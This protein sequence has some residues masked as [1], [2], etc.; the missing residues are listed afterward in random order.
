MDYN[1]L[2]QRA[3]AAYLDMFPPFV[4][5][6][7]AD[8]DMQEEFYSLMKNL[9]QL[10]FDEP[11]LL[12][13]KLNEDDSFPSRYKKPYGKPEL[14][15]NTLKL[16]KAM[17]ML[18]QNM[19]LLGQ[20]EEVN[21]SKKHSDILSRLGVKDTGTLPEGWKW[22][23][24]RE[25]ANLSAFSY[26]L[27]DEIYPYTVD[28]YAGLLGD[29]AFRQLIDWMA[30]QGYKRFDNYHITASSCKLSLTYANPAWGKERPRGG[31]EYKIKHAGISA[32]YDPFIRKPAIFGMCI[33]NGLKP[34][35]QK[36]DAMSESNKDF[37]V[38]HTKRCNKCNYCIQTDKTGS[39]PLAYIPVVHDGTEH[40]LCTY[41]P[42]YTFCWTGIDDGLVSNITEL[43]SFIDGFAP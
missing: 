19:F 40:K 17:N 38:R 20:G 23:S 28:I 37:V 34:Y 25:N 2:E 43:L 18:I 14:Q 31:F 5:D 13:Q 26:C 35:L 9:Y 41:F 16:E 33:P 7:N 36:Y 39:R 22:M 10:L 3:V 15:A 27:F 30:G 42:G 1:N 4:P 11:L 29:G 21:L 12:F 32:Q 24:K 6:P 8:I